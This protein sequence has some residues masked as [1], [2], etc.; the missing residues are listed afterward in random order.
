MKP[1]QFAYARPDHID[2][3]TALLAEHRGAAAILAGG[4]SLVPLLNRR[5]ARPELVVDINRVAGMAFVDDGSGVLRVGAC[6]RQ[7]AL[8]RSS[9]VAGSA[10]LLVAAL[11]RVGHAATRSRGTLGGSIAHAD[12][13]GELPAVLLACDGE[14]VAQ[15]GDGRRTIRA[16]DF[17]RSRHVTALREDEILVEVRIRGRR[18]PGDCIPRGLAAPQ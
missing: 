2:E 12:P 4:Q 6:T 1:S 11:G 16:A 14:V 8:E 18:G 7:L 15:S 3:V 10:P 13:A 9:V 5:A 17:F